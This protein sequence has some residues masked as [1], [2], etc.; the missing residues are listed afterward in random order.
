MTKVKICGLTRKCDIEAVN[1]VQPDYMGF[2]FAESKRR[3]TPQNAYRLREL[4][5]DKIMS[6]GV[7]VDETIEQIKDICAMGI[8][9]IIQ[10]HGHE[11]AAYIERL[12]KES[13]KPI[14]KAVR[15]R[16]KE[17][18][19][20]AELLNSN[21]LLLDAFS[22]KGAGGTGETFDWK[23]IDGVEKPFFLAGGLNSSNILPAISAV[24]PFGVD[25]SSGVEI[26]GFKD[27]GKIVEIMSLIR[28]LN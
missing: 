10:L 7:F 28:N 11:N 4:L 22:D 1:E 3:I 15:V 21:Y 12:R 23:V 27:S 8:I 19:R 26:D 16:S 14:I 17:D 2:V 18:I 13:G 9:D 25:I 20:S 5:N 6:V 24:K